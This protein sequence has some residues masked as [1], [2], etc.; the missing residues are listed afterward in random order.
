MTLRKIA[1]AVGGTLFTEGMPPHIS[2]DTVEAAGVVLDSRKVEK[3][4]VFIAT[5]GERVDG[6]RFIDSVFDAGALGVICEQAPRNPKGAYILVQDSFQALK[7]VAAYYRKQLDIKVVGITGSVGKTKH[8]EILTMR[9]GCR[10][11]CFR[12]A[13]TVRLPFWKWASVI[14][15]KCTAFPKLQDRMCV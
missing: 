6:H 12:Y 5:R 2:A 4:F 13:M 9:W 1:D 3:G 8:R 10:S 7:A 14:L 15:G 11:R